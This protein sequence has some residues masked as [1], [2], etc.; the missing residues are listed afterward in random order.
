MLSSV[1]L[2][3]SVRQHASVVSIQKSPP[4]ASSLPPPSSQSAEL[5]SSCDTAAP[6]TCYTHGP[7]SMSELLSH[8]ILPS[9][10]LAV[11]THP[12]LHPHPY[13]SPANMF[14]SVPFLD[15]Y[16][17][18]NIWY[19]YDLETL[20]FIFFPLLFIAVLSFLQENTKNHNE[21]C[22]RDSLN[23]FCWFNQ[24]IDLQPSCKL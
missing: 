24:Y 19:F 8:F 10:S 2:V 4:S 20:N 12:F 9:P 16:V 6:I 22:S 23:F 13:S 15:A 14:L 21:T 18:V 11:S 3:S 17:C 5:S 7:L 1:A